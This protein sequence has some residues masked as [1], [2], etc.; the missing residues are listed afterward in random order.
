MTR[1]ILIRHGE[2]DTNKTR[3]FTGQMDP[4]LS[5]LGFRQAAC[6]AP[7]LRAHYDIAAVYAADL[8]RAVQTA[9]PTAD[10]LGLPVLTDPRLREI[11]VPRWQGMKY[12]DIALLDPEPLAVWSGDIGHFAMEGAESV[13]DMLTRFIGALRDIA[14]AHP[15]Q[16]AAV[17][18]HATPI[19]ALQTFLETGSLDAMAGTP[20][21]YN[22]SL[23]PV[24][25]DGASF[26]VEAV[27]L[28]A[29]LDGMKTVLK[30]I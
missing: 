16:T 19:R 7:Y 2:S 9:R 30:G 15:D 20:W 12:A 10:L 5:G 23:T 24:L 11:R 18:T 25:F 6:C 27:S 21:V 26:R 29:H 13:Q 22:A 3:V 4:G 14:R 28:T 1:L 8:K 17:F